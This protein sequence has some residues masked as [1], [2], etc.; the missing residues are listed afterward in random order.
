MVESL[1]IDYKIIFY[2]HADSDYLYHDPNGNPVFGNSKV[3]KAAHEIAEGAKLGEVFIFYQRPERRI[4]GLFPRRSSQLYHYINGELTGVMVYRHSNRSED[5]LTTEAQLY[6]QYGSQSQNSEQKIHFLYFGH[7]ISLQDGKR[8]HHTLPDIEVNID[9]FSQGLK[10]FLNGDALRF[11][12]IVVSTCN[13]G[14]PALAG[15]LMPISNTLLASP[16]NLHLSHIDSANLSYLESNPVISSVQL[17][18]LIAEKTFNRLE[19]D[20]HTAITLAV[21]DFEVVRQYRS[22]LDTFRELYDKLDYRPFYADNVD[23]DEVNFFDGERFREGVKTWYKPAG[24]G[25]RSQVTNHSG[26][27]CRPLMQESR[28]E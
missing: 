19:T 14:S 27:G 13:N 10:N 12:L 28:R 1:D 9:S 11:D 23:C 8:Y 16:Q 18:Y 17:A 3:L 6:H 20:I 25:R 5:F 2:I 21:Y 22:E 26:W 15:H 24:F 4:L 7:E